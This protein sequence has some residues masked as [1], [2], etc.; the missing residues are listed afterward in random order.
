MSHDDD[1]HGAPSQGAFDEPHD[2]LLGRPGER[3]WKQSTITDPSLD[4]RGGVFF[5][6]IEMTRMPMILT[7]P[8]QSD[9]P[10][11]FAN[12]AFL[13]LTG[14][15]LEEVLGRNCRLLQ[16][17]LTDRA[18]VAQMRTAVTERRAV[19]VEVLNYRRDGS[20]FWNGVFIGPVYDEAGELLFFFAS[21]LDV[22]PRKEAE[23]NALQSQKMEAIGQLTAGL[24]HDFNNL[25]QVVN[26]SLELMAARREDERAFKRYH[27][28]AANAA[29]RG[30]KLTAQLLSFARRSRLEPR[31]IEISSLISSIVEL[32]ESTVGSRA[33]LQLNLRRRLPD[34]EVDPVHLETALINVVTNARDAIEAGGTITI[35]ASLR[36]VTA[37]EIAGLDQGDHVLLE[38]SDDGHGMP[39]EVLARALEPFFTTKPKGAGT[40]LGLAMAQGFA[41]QSHGVMTL[42]SGEG[43][44]TSVRFYFPVA[45][46][47]D[48]VHA[49]LPDATAFQPETVDTTRPPLILVV[50]DEEA[51]AFLAEETLAEA[52]YKVAVARD[53]DEGLRR[54]DELEQNGGVDLVFS[55]V[56]MPGVRNGLALAQEIRARNP[57]VPILLTTGYNDEMSIQ[58]PQP[59]ALDVL[60]KPYRSRDLIARVQAAL[61]R[62][63]NAGTPHQPSDFGHARS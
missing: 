38:V 32:L 7:D 56:V 57:D 21:Q 47:E 49:L 37:D 52:G 45:S 58:G 9:N 62:R 29:Q 51:I 18:V 14:Y 42:Q 46:D 28:A 39:Q 17:A 36:S 25:L 5:A 40:G 41:R 50:E 3:H 23:G 31:R 26:G 20:P 54:F 60:G 8:R 15:D 34:I 12:N 13:D 53:A 22:S 27:E 61:R 4:H 6:A 33:D 30:A 44:G 10:I 55:D 48:R 63:E 24:A 11:V 35:A 2:G 19:S 59:E 1:A 16:G 43:E